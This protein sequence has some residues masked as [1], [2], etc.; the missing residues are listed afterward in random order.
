MVSPSNTSQGELWCLH[1]AAPLQTTVHDESPQ[2]E[3]E[4]EPMPDLEDANGQIVGQCYLG[5]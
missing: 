3:G 5:G 1:C 2:D 4:D